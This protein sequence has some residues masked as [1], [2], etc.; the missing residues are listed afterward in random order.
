MDIIH[1]IGVQ[2]ATPQAVYDALTTVDGLAGWWTTDTKQ[3]ES[4]LKFRFPPVGGFDMEVPP[5]PS[6][7][8]ISDWH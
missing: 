3:D 6:D 8:Q 5:A 1:R 7:V 2:D 4:I